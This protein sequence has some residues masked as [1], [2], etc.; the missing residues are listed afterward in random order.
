MKF[1]GRLFSHLGRMSLGGKLISSFLTVLLLTAALGG[2]SYVSLSR[3]HQA[4]DELATRWLPEIG[5]LTTARA[6]I[7]E[8]REFEVKH[9]HAADA[10]YMSEYEEKMAA[11]V[12]VVDKNLADAGA[13]PSSADERKLLDGVTKGWKDYLASNKRVVELGRAG[14]QDDARDIG[15]GA[16]K[17]TADDTIGALDRLTAFAFERGAA[18]GDHA[19]GTYRV[20]RLWVLAL[21]LGSLCI[22]LCLAL[23]IT[24]GVRR[25]LGGEPRVAVE[26]VRAVASGNLTTPIALARGDSTSLMASLKEM[27][28]SLSRVVAT[29]RQGSEGVATASAEI[30]SGNSDLSARTE[31][32]ASALQQTTAS[33]QQLGS[34]VNH[35]AENAHQADELA[36]GASQVA[37]QGGEVVG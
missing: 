15:E 12:K 35:N 36:R 25:Q 5:H 4:S 32:Q 28:A 1:L 22:G 21:V 13:A 33:M 24:R 6:A 18:A 2:I 26:L 37:I 8:V 9:S 16:S 30:A 11:A 19:A 7:L 23:A 27:Q 31:Q 3:V 10:G 14:K 34:T 17:M 29:V 20:A